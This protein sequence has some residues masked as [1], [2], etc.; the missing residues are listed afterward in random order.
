MRTLLNV[1]KAECLSLEEVK[2]EEVSMYEQDWKFGVHQPHSL[3]WERQH[4]QGTILAQ[5]A[6][7]VGGK[8]CEQEVVYTSGGNPE[9]VE[10]FDQDGT[11]L[12][13]THLHVTYCFGWKVLRPG[14]G[15]CDCQDCNEGASRPC[16]RPVWTDASEGEEEWFDAL[17]EKASE[18]KSVHLEGRRANTEAS[19][20]HRS[21][22][23]RSA[24]M[25]LEHDMRGRILD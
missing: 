24:G 9:S 17:D 4:E 15:D 20:P 18:R 13:S 5:L 6:R 11:T 1:I 3:D 19:R 10:D 12:C 14:L 22:S 25:R 7:E 8:V 2:V 16:A 21:P 23:H